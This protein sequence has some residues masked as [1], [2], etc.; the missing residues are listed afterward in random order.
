MAP[1]SFLGLVALSLFLL[2][3][4]DGDVHS[5]THSVSATAPQTG[6]QTATV[7]T[8]QSSSGSGAAGESS[9]DAFAATIAKALDENPQ[10]AAAAAAAFGGGG[11]TRGA[12]NYPGAPGPVGGGY[13][14]GIGAFP[15]LGGGVFPGLGF[16]KGMDIRY[17]TIS[18]ISWIYFLLIYCSGLHLNLDAGAG[19]GGVG[20]Y[21]PIIEKVKPA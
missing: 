19:L 10:L 9:N 5:H 12:Y 15:G 21:Y 1:T 8:V 17:L 16:G 4:G 6:G 7:T 20:G 3:Q 14:G 18:T 13:P 2:V 11:Q